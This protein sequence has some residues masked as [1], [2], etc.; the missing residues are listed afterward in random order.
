MTELTTP[1]HSRSRRRPGVLDK[2]PGALSTID[3]D[4][5][6]AG[7]RSGCRAT[8]SPDQWDPQ[9][10]TIARARQVGR[11]AI[12]ICRSCP[13]QAHCLEREMR[14]DYLGPGRQQQIRAGFTGGELRLLR[15]RWLTGV[16][17]LDLL[18]PVTGL[19]E[20]QSVS[21]PPTDAAG[22]CPTGDGPARGI[23]R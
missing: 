11:T 17:V 22:D 10:T 20:P 18:W 15:Q 8:C 9:V 2:P 21:E 4:L 1:S 19:D 16:S 12:Q 23:S 14:R 13:V 5:L 7:P 6:V 3:L